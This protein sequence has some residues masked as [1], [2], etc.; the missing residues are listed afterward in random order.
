VTAP[1][2]S[3]RLEEGLR[4]RALLAADAPPLPPGKPG[5]PWFVVLLLG[6]SGWLAGL[7][8]LLFLGL[9]FK[10]DGAPGF[11]VIGAV[12][13]AGA[14]GLYR[15]ADGAFQE[16]LA[17]AVSIAGHVS[18]T[19]AIGLGTDSPAGTAFAVAAIQAAWAVVVPNRAARALATL[20]GAIA[21]ALAVRFAWWGHDF[22]HHHRQVSLLAALVGWVVVWGPVVVAALSAVAGEVRWMAAGRARLVRPLLVGL[23]LALGF[24][25]L[26]SQ[27][28]PA[29]LFWEPEGPARTD[30]LA[31][32][33]L[34]SV[35]GSILALALAHALRSRPLMGAAIAAALL[36]VVHFYL[37][38]GATLLT[39]AAIMGVV[40]LLLLAGAALLERRGRPA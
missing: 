23:L 27:P 9:L 30:W 39:K 21:W 7:F 24:G 19:V 2:V 4:G 18:I 14:F 16:Q 6:F 17:L 11:A 13:L 28:T 34:L 26:V 37:L 36:H 32:W 8:G 33:P 22:D 25:T 38:V 5:R 15:V 31:L 35:G 10:P 1:P 3:A 40:G 12:L 29:L 20:F